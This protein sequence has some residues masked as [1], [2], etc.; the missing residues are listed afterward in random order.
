MT[1]GWTEAGLEDV[2]HPGPVV[3]PAARTAV[4]AYRD[5]RCNG[6]HDEGDRPFAFYDT[7]GNGRLDRDD[8]ELW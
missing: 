4:D 3:P 1:Y 5:H 8:V 2:Q 6:I 7:D